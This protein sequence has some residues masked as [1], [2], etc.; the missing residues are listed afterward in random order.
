MLG[1][2]YCERCITYECDV[3]KEFLIMYNYSSGKKYRLI[4]CPDKKN[5]K[6]EGRK[7]DFLISD[8]ISGEIVVVEHKKV[9]HSYGRGKEGERR[10]AKENIRNILYKYIFYIL[11]KIIEEYRIKKKFIVEIVIF[12]NTKEKYI[13][14][15]FIPKI[16]DDLK[17]KIVNNQNYIYE[18]DILKVKIIESF[19]KISQDQILV[20]FPENTNKGESEKGITIDEFFQRSLD[21]N[22]LIRKIDATISKKCKGKFEKYNDYKKVVLIELVFSY[23]H[24]LV[25]NI[26]K[27]SPNNGFSFIKLKNLFIN[28]YNIDDYKFIDEII[29]YYTNYDIKEIVKLK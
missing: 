19:L 16:Y 27:L 6:E 29:V 11:S 10:I 9:F 5:E 13:E 22:G 25:V 3:L 20:M 21:Y 12:N 24:E 26:N 18:D 17:E 28:N 4:E 1:A 23:G 7:P 14:E 8:D 2:R 15:D